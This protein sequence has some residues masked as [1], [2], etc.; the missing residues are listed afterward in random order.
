MNRFVA[1][2]SEQLKAVGFFT[3]ADNAGYA[4]SIY[5]TFSG[6]SLSSLLGSN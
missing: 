2:G 4:I 6:G 3:E 1:Q 5:D